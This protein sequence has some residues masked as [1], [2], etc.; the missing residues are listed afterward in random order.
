LSPGSPT[1]SAGE[2]ALTLP[3]TP[4]SRSAKPKIDNDS[5]RFEDPAVAFYSD[6]QKD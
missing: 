2:Y 4:D 6:V 5:V 1:I 3:L